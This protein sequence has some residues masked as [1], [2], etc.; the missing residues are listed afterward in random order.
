MDATNL[1][2]MIVTVELHAQGEQLRYESTIARVENAAHEAREMLARCMDWMVVDTYIEPPTPDG[3]LVP[4]GRKFSLDVQ[5][6]PFN[7]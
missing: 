2:Y 4:S 1:K 5:F 7:G 3:D 6:A